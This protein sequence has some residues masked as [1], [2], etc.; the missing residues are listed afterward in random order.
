[1]QTNETIIGI[2]LGTT[3][4]LAATVFEH[5]AEALRESGGGP[6][7]PSVL[8]RQDGRWTVGEEKRL[9]VAR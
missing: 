2:D 4:S 7:I 6:I 3:N 5:G 9:R 8:T 1:M